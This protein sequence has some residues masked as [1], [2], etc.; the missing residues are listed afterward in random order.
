M[1]YFR[2]QSAR[3]SPREGGIFREWGGGITRFAKGKMNC[4]LKASEEYCKTLCGDLVNL[5]TPRPPPL[6]GN[7]HHSLECLISNKN[8]DLLLVAIKSGILPSE[9]T[10]LS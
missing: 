5:P 9:V 3:L 8:E 4:N 1:Y 2:D 10:K 7:N 6:G